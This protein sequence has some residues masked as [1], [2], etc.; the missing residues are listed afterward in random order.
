[1]RAAAGGQWCRGVVHDCAGRRA[2]DA[3]ADAAADPYAQISDVERFIRLGGHLRAMDAVLADREHLAP[4][5]D[6]SQLNPY[7][8]HAVLVL[9]PIG[10]GKSTLGRMLADRITQCG[11]PAVHIDA[12]DLGIGGE[13]VMRLSGE[14]NDFTRAVIMRTLATGAV[15]VISLG[16]GQI[17]S[18]RRGYDR[19]IELTGWFSR[20]M[21]GADLRIT[22]L[23]GDLS[24]EQ[25]AADSGDDFGNVNANDN[26]VAT[27]AGGEGEGGGG[28]GGVCVAVE[29]VE[30]VNAHDWP[31]ERFDN[32]YAAAGPLVAA[33]LAA[34]LARGEW[35]RH[36]DKSP[37]DFE[38]EIVGKSRSNA[39]SARALAIA[40]ETVY[41]FPP[42]RYVDGAAVA[43]PGIDD[44]AAQIAAETTSGRVVPPSETVA[45]TQDRLLVS[46]DSPRTPRYGHI[47]MRHGFALS[48]R[49]EFLAATGPG[50]KY[51][52]ATFSG[53]FVAGVAINPETGLP[54]RGRGKKELIV[55]VVDGIQERPNAHVSVYTGGLPAVLMNNV[56][57]AVRAGDAQCTLPHG[58][59]EI[60][61]ALDVQEPTTIRADAR[62]MF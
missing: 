19:Q 8:G 47:T 21:R 12:D 48:A 61:F 20:A 46:V 27:S 36:P 26:A 3:A 41:R 30:D 25:C 23:F 5:V 52:G 35:T 4:H 7:A 58:N 16:G 6:E 42:A 34:R 38:T 31:P 53:R 22:T 32:I 59:T 2:T 57:A 18:D 44:A 39:G 15:A 29:P 45:T 50:G 17:V 54:R 14:R 13:R 62:F 40:A 37:R 10:F 11:A 51:V 56:T 1:V 28:W 9:G 43:P 55:V 24:G 60:V 49:D 33:T